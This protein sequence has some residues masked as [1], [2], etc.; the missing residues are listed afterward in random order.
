MQE[1]NMAYQV[2]HDPIRRLQYDQTGS[3]RS[4]ESDGRNPGERRKREEPG[5]A[6]RRAEE[7][8][9]KRAEAEAS[10]RHTAQPVMYEFSRLCFKADII[11]PL[12]DQESFR[13]ITPGGTFQMTKADFYRD[14]ANVVKSRSYREGGI[15]HYPTVPQKALRYR[16]G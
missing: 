6:Q 3:A 12:S 14:F 11:E 13:V 8:R 16:V 15:Y 7:E 5:T 4:A 9:S 10:W 2:L 1:I